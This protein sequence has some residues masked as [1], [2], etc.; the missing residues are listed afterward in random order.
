[1]PIGEYVYR[2]IGLWL[3]M[4]IINLVIKVNNDL[5]VDLDDLFDIDLTLC[6]NE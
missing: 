3:L 4:V 1:M 2:G 6:T 5:L